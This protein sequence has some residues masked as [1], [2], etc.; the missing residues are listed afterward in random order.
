M[1]SR[2]RAGT[3]A[4]VKRHL[5][6]RNCGSVACSRAAVVVPHAS[7]DN[8]SAGRRRC[9]R[10]CANVHVTELHGHHDV[11][12]LSPSSSREQIQRPASISIPQRPQSPYFR[13]SLCASGNCSDLC[14]HVIGPHGD[15]GV[16]KYW[17]YG[18]KPHMHAPGGH[19][20]GRREA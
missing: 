12:S 15:I 3:D 4:G 11:G 20:N 18:P 8:V 2:N 10:T 9:N 7:T 1:C 19:K 16:P 13:L 14:V 5:D 6:E 17:P